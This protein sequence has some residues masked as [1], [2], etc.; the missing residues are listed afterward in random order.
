[1]YR[2]QISTSPVFNLIILDVNG[3][4]NSGYVVTTNILVI[5]TRYYWRVNA[6]NTGGISQWSQV[7]TFTTI[8][9]TGVNLISSDIPAEYKLYNNYPNPFNPNT[10]IKYQITNSKFST[11]KIFD[12][13][14]REVKTLVKEFQKAGVY[15]VSFDADGLPSGIYFYRLQS[16]DF[17]DVKRM[18]LIK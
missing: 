4:V 11:L 5:C 7:R 16:G 12:I 17:A 15:E 6:S 3:L 10:I 14:G 1:M 18:I 13:L 9:P 2:I 8:C